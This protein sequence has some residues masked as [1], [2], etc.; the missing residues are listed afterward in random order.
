MDKREK[1]IEYLT[2]LRDCKINDLKDPFLGREYGLAF[3][4][5][6]MACANEN[7]TSKVLSEKMDVSMS[8]MS[9]LIQKL[10]DRNLIYRVPSKEDGRVT[11]LFLT[12][13]GKEE[14]HRITETSIEIAERVIEKL[15]IEKVDDF[16][17]TIY[18]IKAIVDESCGGEELC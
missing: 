10:E 17:N 12:E 14:G 6:Y 11:L 18:K 9:T 3:V 1:A 15:G 16:I 8:R 5:S 13:K 4:I 7:I 2:K